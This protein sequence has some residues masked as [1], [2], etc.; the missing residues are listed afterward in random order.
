MYENS[1]MFRPMREADAWLEFIGMW[2]PSS[3][4]CVDPTSTSDPQ[5]DVLLMKRSPWSTLRPAWSSAHR[6]HAMACNRPPET[7]RRDQAPSH[8]GRGHGRRLEK[9]R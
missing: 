7:R 2:P 8:V 5:R 3:T 9:T 4:S 1:A 6:R